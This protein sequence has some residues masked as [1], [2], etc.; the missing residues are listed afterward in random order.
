MH[1]AP[2]ALWPVTLTCERSLHAHGPEAG[3]P[4][5]PS[6]GLS[7]PPHSR[8]RGLEPVPHSLRRGHSQHPTHNAGASSRCPT[9]PTWAQ[10]R[11]PTLTV[12]HTP[13]LAKATGQRKQHGGHHSSGSSLCKEASL[14]DEAPE[15]DAASST[16]SGGGGT[17][18]TVSGHSFI[19]M[20]GGESLGERDIQRISHPHHCVGSTIVAVQ[21]GGGNRDDRR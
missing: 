8:C 7:G 16:P 2:L 12:A 19:P 18:G 11:C 21:G 17:G 15:S 10:S 14:W 5:P 6:R 9:H 3:I 1:R 4:Y 20:R 13:R